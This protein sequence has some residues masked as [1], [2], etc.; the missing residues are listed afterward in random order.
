MAIVPHC[1]G[2]DGEHVTLQLAAVA[3]TPLPNCPHVV[4][5]KPSN[6]QRLLHPP[7]KSGLT[8][9][10]TQMGTLRLSVL[11]SDVALQAEN[12]GLHE[13]VQVPAVHEA[14][15]LEVVHGWPQRPQACVGP[16]SP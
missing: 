13:S 12:R 5:P 9:V 4:A 7:Q 11:V 15:P 2:Y 8:V 10:S 6:G 16:P 3:L 1:V 14:L